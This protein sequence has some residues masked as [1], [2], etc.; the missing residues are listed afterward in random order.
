MVASLFRIIERPIYRERQRSH[1]RKLDRPVGT[2]LPEFCRS[3]K[4]P[5]CFRQAILKVSYLRCE[6]IIILLFLYN[7]IML[8]RKL[9]VFGVF[10]RLKVTNVSPFKLKIGRMAPNRPSLVYGTA[11]LRRTGERISHIMH[12]LFAFEVQQ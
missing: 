10:L 2:F 6:T 1:G 9:C 3:L 7:D 5:F 4:I 11:T 8:K 12:I